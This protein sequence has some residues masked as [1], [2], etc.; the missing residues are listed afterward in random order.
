MKRFLSILGVFLILASL[1]AVPSQ[2]SGHENYANNIVTARNGVVRVFGTNPGSSSGSIGSGFAI[3]TAGEPTTIFAT[4]YHVVEGMSSVYVLVDNEWRDSIAEW[5]GRA[6]NVHA[7]RCRVL[8]E[9]TPGPDYAILQAERL[10]T[11]RV[12]LPIMRSHQAYPGDTIFALGYPGVSDEVTGTDPADIDSMT[13]TRGT[14]SRFTTYERR[15]S[16]VI[17]IDADI[18]HG[19][20]GGPLVTEQGYV[21]GLNTWGVGNEDGTVNLALEVDYVIDKLDELIANGT[22]PGFTYT[23]ITERPEDAPTPPPTQAPSEATEPPVS[24]SRAPVPEP[25]ATTEKPVVKEE[26]DYTLLYVGIGAAAVLFGVILLLARRNRIAPNPSGGIANAGVTVPVPNASVMLQGSSG[27]YAGRQIP[28]GKVMT[29]GRTT[30]CDVTFPEGTPGISRVHCQVAPGSGVVILTD[31]G[32]SMGTFLSNGTRL[33]PNQPHTLR[34]G[35]SFYLGNQSQSFRVVIPGAPLPQ[36]GPQAARV[37]ARYTLVGVAGSFA[38][39]RYPIDRDITLGRNP[40]STLPFPQNASGVS[41]RHC[42]LSPRE[43]GVVVM[44]LG[45]TYGTMLSNGTKL[46]PNQKTLI[47]RGDCFYVGSQSNQFRIE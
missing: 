22:L 13:V 7:I 40:D 2:A 38:G 3:G 35:E 17:Q 15:H 30:G 28:V 44:D 11:E 39:R 46:T 16:K 29:F 9:N 47:R 8:Y 37:S 34:N 42:M 21:I 31:L 26:P 36:T 12:A 25:P 5:G 24:E 10:V 43:N 41:G 6:D 19:N 27:Q 23:L 45:S 32:S 33:N 4:N 18:N 14:I 20:S 1:L